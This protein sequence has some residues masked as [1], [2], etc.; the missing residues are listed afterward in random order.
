MKKA[1]GLSALEDD[2][3]IDRLPGKPAQCRRAA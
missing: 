1:D 3:R 2:F